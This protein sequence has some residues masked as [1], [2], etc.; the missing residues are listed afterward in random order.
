MNSAIFHYAN[1]E[2]IT[3]LSFEDGDLLVC[4]TGEA[5]GKRAGVKQTVKGMSVEEAARKVL[6]CRDCASAFEELT[7][8][9]FY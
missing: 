3:L 9:S 1:G 4:Y 7:G 2:A 6:E 8:H 5:N